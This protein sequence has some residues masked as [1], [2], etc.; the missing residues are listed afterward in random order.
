MTWGG[1]KLLTKAWRVIF[2]SVGWDELRRIGEARAAKLVAY[3]P[4]VVIIAYYSPAF[5]SKLHQ[6]FTD[7]PTLLYSNEFRL[8]VIGLITFSVG[9]ILFRW[10]CPNAIK[11]YPDDT[12]YAIK[13]GPAWWQ[14]SSIES[15]VRKTVERY[16]PN[17]ADWND[18]IETI[19]YYYRGQSL[20]LFP[21]RIIIAACFLIG[22]F[23]ISLPTACRTW[24][25]V[26]A[27]QEECSEGR[28]LSDYEHLN[29]CK[30]RLRYI[31]L[32]GVT[33]ETDFSRKSS[34]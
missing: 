31:D 21:I 25:V 29:P 33:S 1:E 11:K 24:T 5:E 26:R 28:C 32:F 13:A 3:F 6:L 27:Y 15:S 12:G 34:K 14:G 18:S 16:A 9:E 10:L 19:R 4:F 20:T 22:L 30:G 7:S 2:T 17:Y 23:Y 8:I